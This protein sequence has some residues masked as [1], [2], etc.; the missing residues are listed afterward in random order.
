M[1]VI[2]VPHSNHKHK[3]TIETFYV[4]AISYANCSQCAWFWWN[5]RYHARRNFMYWHEQQV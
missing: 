3:L 2:Q 4:P 1:T 5:N